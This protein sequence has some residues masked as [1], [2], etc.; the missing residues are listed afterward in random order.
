MRLGFIS[1]LLCI[2]FQ[3][4]TQRPVITNFSPLKGDVGSIVTINGANFE[5]NATNNYVFFG[6]VKALV[7]TAS[8][9]QLTVTVPSG[10][11]FAPITILTPATTLISVSSNY[12]TPTFSVVNKKT[13]MAYDAKVDFSVGVKPVSEAVGDFDGDGKLDIAV[14]NNSNNTLSVLRNIGTG[15]AMNFAAKVDFNTGSNPQTVN[16]GDFDGDGKFDLVVTNLWD[17][18][19]SVYRNTSTTGTIS[20]SAK[21]DYPT[22]LNPA[23][24]AIGDFDNDGKSD[25]AVA[26][27]SGSLI[28]NDGTVSIYRNISSGTGNVNFATRT[29]LITGQ[30]PICIA[31]GDLDG[32]NKLDLAVTNWETSSISVFR[33]L[34]SLGNIGFTSKSDMLTNQNPLFVAM[35][36]LDGDTKLDIAVASSNKLSVMKNRSSFG[37]VAFDTKQDFTPEGSPVSLDIDDLN[38]DGKPDITVVQV[39]NNGN[40]ISLF[41]NTS[42]DGVIGFDEKV[43]LSSGLAPYQVIIADLNGDGKSDIVTVNSGSDNISVLKSVPNFVNSLPP[44]I[45]TSFLPLNA[46]VGTSI[47]I[48]GSGFNFV[49]DN[50]IVF[51]GGVKAKV[52]SATTSKLIVEIPI[53][54]SYGPITVMNKGT[55]QTG[56]S[57]TIFN[58]IFHPNKSSLTYKDF[59]AFQ[60]IRTGEFLFSSRD[61]ETADIDGDGKLEMLIANTDYDIPVISILRNKSKVDSVSFDVNLNITTNKLPRKIKLADLDQD[62]KLDLIIIDGFNEEVSIYKNNSTIGSIAFGN[63]ISY[64]IGSSPSDL[65]IADVDGDGLLDVLVSIWDNQVAVYRNKGNLLLDTKINYAVGLSPS[66][67][68]TGDLDGDNKH[69]IIIA[70]YDGRSFSV[71]K[72]NSVSGLVNFTDRTDFAA[73]IRS[74]HVS[75]GDLNADGKLDVVVVNKKD[76]TISV[77]KNISNPGLIQF[78][79]QLTYKSGT[80]T[81]E[82]AIG[83]MNGDGKPDIIVAN[84]G[85][86]YNFESG[87]I[88]LLKNIS[89]NGNLSFDDSQTIR[90]FGLYSTMDLADMDGDGKLDIV[91]IQSGNAVSIGLNKPSFPTS[92]VSFAPMSATNGATVTIEGVNFNA[93]L[94]NNIVYF[95]NLKA[96]IVKASS[97]QLVVKVPAGASYAPITVLNI[98][99]GLTAVSKLN[100]TPQF[101]PTKTLITNN[102]F[103]DKQ[104]FTTGRAPSA[105]NS[106]DFD[107]DGLLDLVSANYFG[108]SISVLR[109]NTNSGMIGYAEN[110]DIETGLYPQFVEIADMN[111]DGKLDI[112]VA[113]SGDNNFKIL[114]NQSNGVGNI[115]FDVKYSFTTGGNPISLAVSDLNLDGKL[116]VVVVNQSDNDISV[117]L[118][119]GTNE[120]ISF[121]TSVKYPVGLDPKSIVIGDVNNDSYNDILVNNQG[122]RSINVLNNNGSGGLLSKVD[123]NT[124]SLPS[125]IAVGDLNNDGKLDLIVTHQAT[126]S[127]YAN[128]S[129]LKNTGSAF[130]GQVTYPTDE[131]PY[132]V[133]LGDLDGDGKIDI[134]VANNGSSNISLYKNSSTST[135][136][137]FNEKVTIAAMTNPASIHIADADGDGRPD[138][139]TPATSLFGASIGIS[140]NVYPLTITANN[141]TICTGTISAFN[142]QSFTVSGLV[143]NDLVS[144]VKLTSP[145]AASS[146][147][148]GTY[149]IIPSDAVGVGINNYKISYVNGELKKEAPIPGKRLNP[150]DVS[151]NIN[152]KVQLNARNLGVT[153]TQY[154][155][156][157]FYNL[158]NSKI[159]GPIAT[160]DKQLEYTIEMKTPSGCVTVDTV[161]TRVHSEQSIYVPNAFSPNGDGINDV[162]KVKL[163]GFSKLNNFLIYNK[164][165]WTLFS[166]TDENTGWN[167]TS[168]YSLPAGTYYWYVSATDMNGKIIQKNGS[169]LLMR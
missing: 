16:Y 141:Q 17:N 49:A 21:M 59:A 169:V 41:N 96:A 109:K 45:I 144:S 19:I 36:D 26:N 124:G 34:S 155:W 47:T 102:D 93:V 161:L 87:E 142:N 108:N 33:N 89:E 139:I 50:N 160:I 125:S 154:S 110:I 64:S 52:L 77:F 97:T 123:Y 131:K 82:A 20:F 132:A 105:I 56:V 118:N 95:G 14:I 113:N 67:I 75:I 151:L 85:N 164:Y 130:A 100:F 120:K 101:S 43:S 6:G 137:K 15:G 145:G 54:A 117:Y 53:G 70:N 138:L 166:T 78:D 40:Q 129:V 72:N 122:S 119:N 60:S 81:E 114:I 168:W 66:H 90:S 18:T 31:L 55:L 92:I 88:T 7:N 156:T 127:T 32:D 121:S 116:D 167:G 51:F 39:G 58:P 73:G 69:D 112:L 165:R 128:V 11:S 22:D 115:Q 28:T 136:L 29:S 63:K 133:K 79:N 107:G 98:G 74:E 38:G 146:A 147:T 23:Y 8:T 80:E 148:A 71:L 83:D 27:Y 149:T 25:I 65:S 3:A 30:R 62:G 12:F 106:G 46:Q 104:E 4:F 153:G 159:A 157:P 57:K 68:L 135:D 86:L 24:A 44:P 42:V 150:I 84:Y 134:A 158:N 13:V 61:L 163:V 99:K 2:S 35:G 152:N 94:A 76:K 143:N 126:T 10:A 162:L 103:L 91:T 9:T 48:N 5:P 37:L 111:G 1:V 140:K